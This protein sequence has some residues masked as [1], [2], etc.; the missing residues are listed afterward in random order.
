M[1]KQ[2]A[3]SVPVLED[4]EHAE[5]I[6]RQVANVT[7]V[8]ASQALTDL[9]GVDVVLKAENLQRTGA[10]KLR[11]AFHRMSKLTAAERKK[12]VV[13]A[14]A[15]N[16]A[17]GV[18]LA[19]K[20]LGIKATI[21]MPV[22]A[23]LPKFEATK[24]YGADVVLEGAVF[25]ETLAAAQAYAAKKGAIFIPPYDHLDVVLGQGTV[26]LEIL[27]QVPDVENIIVAIG[28]G[29]LAAGVATAAKLWAAK[30]K[31]K[32]KVF[33]VQSENTAAYIP[34]LKAGK[35]VKIEAT[36]TIADGISVSLP[37]K[38]PFELIKKNI[39]KVVAVSDEDISKAILLLLER[40]KVVV[41][42]AGAAPVAALLSGA[43]KPKGK[44]V[45]VLSGGNIDPL[46][47]TKVIS[48][49]LVAAER[50]TDVSVM[51][52]D[53]PGQLVKTAEAIASVHGN[54]VEVLHTRNGKGLEISEVELRLSVETSGHAHREQVFKA[55]K[56]AG[57]KPKANN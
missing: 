28:G 23:S 57:L 52:P 40:A 18:A 39:D 16:H 14:S 9:T 49:G 53:R 45:V 30:H 27:D 26:G 1:T 3:F 37:G 13:A 5:I 15:G 21:F 11:G 20:K 10:Y 35:P 25:A 33:G 43:I 4:F 54:V 24:K 38:I 31:R 46:L 47:L 36:R 51:L 55:L 19:A 2:A 22:G 34:S 56:D 29:G 8:F 17:Q 48:H 7:P 32:I 12:G 44:T 42:P 41:E 50:Y 6:V